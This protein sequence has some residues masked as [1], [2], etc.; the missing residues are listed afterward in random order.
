VLDNR[1]T[2]PVTAKHRNNS[3][4]ITGLYINDKI[5]RNNIQGNNKITWSA[6]QYD[7]HSMCAKKKYENTN[8]VIKYERNINLV[9]YVNVLA[10]SISSK[11]IFS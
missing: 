1:Q 11:H 5:Y 8:K 3:E 4:K 10:N 2:R 9:E 6:V 7:T